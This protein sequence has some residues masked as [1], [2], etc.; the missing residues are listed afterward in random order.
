MRVRA[1]RQGDVEVNGTVKALF[2]G[3]IYDLPEQLV[4]GVDWLE[5]VVKAVEGPP[6]DKAVRPQRNKG[7]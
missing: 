3:Q 7:V 4:S 1:L 6:S 2:Q 5:P